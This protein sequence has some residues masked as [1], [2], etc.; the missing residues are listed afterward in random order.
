MEISAMTISMLQNLASTIAGRE[1]GD[2]WALHW[3]T[4]T[5]KDKLKSAY[6]L[7]LDKV[8]KNADS[9]LY[10]SLY[11]ELLGWKV[12]EYKIYYQRICIIW[13]KKDF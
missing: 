12:A 8:R 6:L 10:Y 3:I 2:H 4:T 11:F 13:M 5:H 9:A 7:P 1:V